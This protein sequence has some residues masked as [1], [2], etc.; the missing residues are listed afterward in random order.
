MF[1]RTTVGWGAE[2]RVRRKANRRF[3]VN[4]KVSM[5]TTGAQSYWWSSEKL[6]KTYF[7]ILP[8]RRKECQIVNPTNR[9]SPKSKESYSAVPLFFKVRGV[10]TCPLALK[11]YPGIPQDIGPQK[12]HWCTINICG[13][14]VLSS[15][16]MTHQSIQSICHFM[17]T[18]SMNMSFTYRSSVKFCGVLL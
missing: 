10:I 9:I 5:W 4:K 16:H 18:S 8:L 12:Y 13:V 2:R 6:S 11:E 15:W 3:N 7:Y 17:L 1:L 14:Y